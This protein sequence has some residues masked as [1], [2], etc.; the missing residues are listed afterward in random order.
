M[1]AH[2]AQVCWTTQHLEI[3]RAEL[4]LNTHPLQRSYIYNPLSMSDKTKLERLAPETA[5]VVELH[6]EPNN[7]LQPIDIGLLEEDKTC[8]VCQGALVRP[9]HTRKD[10][11]DDI[12][13]SDSVVKLPCGH[14]YG[15]ECITVW[16]GT[17]VSCPYCTTTFNAVPRPHFEQHWLY[18]LFEPQASN[19]KAQLDNWGRWA[20]TC[21][22]ALLAIPCLS[23]C[24]MEDSTKLDPGSSRRDAI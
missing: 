4:E 9:G 8:A 13:E 19:H 14:I 3:Y 12:C 10:E 15:R 7:L 16:L 2:E 24:A 21:I 23:A 20:A 17:R 11:D 18:P 1:E 22:D 6:N 5:R